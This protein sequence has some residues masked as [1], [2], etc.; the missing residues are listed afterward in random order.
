[1]GFEGLVVIACG[2]GTFLLR[3]L[4]IWRLR[5]RQSTANAGRQ[6]AQRGHARVQRFLAGIGPAALSALLLVAVWP[7]FRDASQPPRLLA[8]ALALIVIYVGKRLIRS[9]AGS[10]L[11]G[12]LTYGAVMHWWTAA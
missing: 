5:R 10:T 11:A 4:P 1:M 2:A 3:F 7:F 12:A 8:A 9:V 6:T